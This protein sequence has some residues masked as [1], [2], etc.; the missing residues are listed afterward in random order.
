MEYA[1]P[2]LCYG[3]TPLL[4]LPAVIFTAA[5][6]HKEIF[7]FCIGL[8]QGYDARLRFPSFCQPRL[9]EC[10][11]P[12]YL[13]ICATPIHLLD[14]APG[15]KYPFDRALHRMVFSDK[16]S[17]SRGCACIFLVDSRP[18]VGNLF[19]YCRSPCSL[20]LH[21]CRWNKYKVSTKVA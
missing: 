5:I 9:A 21:L 18:E 11:T 10:S 3:Y 14:Y 20:L 17:S 19:G 7:H 1:N 12:A 2:E 4:N 16:L 15:L 8:H 6:S 13:I